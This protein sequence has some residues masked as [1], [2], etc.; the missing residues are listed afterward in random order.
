MS[1]STVNVRSGADRSGR[2]HG[3]H[4]R[5]RICGWDMWSLWLL[6][7]DSVSIPWVS[8]HVGLEG[9]EKVV[10]HKTVTGI[11]VEVGLQEMPDSYDMDSNDS[12]GSLITDEEDDEV[13]WV[14]DKRPAAHLARGRV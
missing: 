9:N 5:M 10:Q 13:V 12:G 14:N 7:G 11:C 8:S 3:A 6:L 2:A 4:W 1:D